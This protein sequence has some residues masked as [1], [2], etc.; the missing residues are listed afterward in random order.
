MR[1]EEVL[2]RVKGERNVLQTITKRK[3]K[4]IGRIWCRNCFLGHFIQREIEERKELT[5][6]RGRRCKQLM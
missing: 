5:G 6:R 1:N 4:W 3:A 2:Q